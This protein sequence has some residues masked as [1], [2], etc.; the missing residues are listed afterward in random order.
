MREDKPGI[1]NLITIYAA[2]EGKTT[3]AV[4]REFEGSG[5]GDFKLKVGEAVAAKFKPIREEYA[6][7]MADKAYLQQTAAEGA[8]HAAYIA[9]KTLRK[10]KKKVGFVQF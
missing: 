2:I 1:S 4:E 6:R 10:V 8:Q 3:D 7:F 5:Y 9:E